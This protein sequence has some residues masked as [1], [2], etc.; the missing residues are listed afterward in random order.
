[1]GHGH[2]HRHGHLR[3]RL[4]HRHRQHRMAAIRTLPAI[5]PLS[6]LGHSHG[7]ELGQQF[8]RRSDLFAHDAVSE[9]CLDVC[10]LCGCL[11]GGVGLCV[12]DLSGDEGVGVG[13]C[14]GDSE[15]GVWGAGELEEGEG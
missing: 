1:M 8:P 6:R 5:R 9:P 13:G 7:Y 11:C 14:E 4:R 3:L 10:Y 15:G 2:P 12:E